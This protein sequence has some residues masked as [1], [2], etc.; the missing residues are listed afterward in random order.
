MPS[1]PITALDLLMSGL[2]M[3]LL[4]SAATLNCI[5]LATALTGANGQGNRHRPIRWAHADSDSS[6]SARRDTLGSFPQEALRVPVTPSHEASL[7][8]RAGITLASTC[9]C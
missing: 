2:V 6:V 5:R 8:R 3:V 1:V 4:L 9:G 7:E